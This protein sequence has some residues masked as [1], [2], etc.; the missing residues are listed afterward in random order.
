MPRERE[1]SEQTAREI[2]EEIKRII[3]EGLEKVRHILETRR[4]ALDAL[5]ARL[6]EKEVIDSDELKKVIEAGSPSPVIVPGTAVSPKRASSNPPEP[7]QADASAP[8]AGEAKIGR[9]AC[10][11]RV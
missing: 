11:E 3:H 7:P 2:D 5:A 4:E 6:I 1:H 10:R 8:D 9:A